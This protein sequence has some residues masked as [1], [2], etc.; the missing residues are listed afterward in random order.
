MW[1]YGNT[2][3]FTLR[4][5]FVVMPSLIA[6]AVCVVLLIGHVQSYQQRYNHHHNRIL[7]RSGS[8]V[9]S[10][11]ASLAPQPRAGV[12]RSSLDDEFV[13]SKPVVYVTDEQ[14]EG[15]LDDM[16]YSGDVKGYIKK[17]ALNVITED[18]AEYVEERI[19]ASGDADEIVALNEVLSIVNGR[20]QLTDGLVNSDEVFEKRLDRILFTPPNQRS[21]WLEDNRG[22]LT[23]GFV[24]YIQNE[25]KIATDSDS[26]VVLAS[27]LQL[28]GQATG[29]ELLEKDVS[30]ELF[31]SA[32]ATLGDQFKKEV[33]TIDSNFRDK[34]EQILAG[35]MFSNN[36]ILEDVLNNLHV[37]NE[38]FLSFLQNKVDLS[39]DMEERVGLQSLLDTISSGE[40]YENLYIYSH[41]FLLCILLL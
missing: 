13:S 24:E 31:Q 20:L 11:A 17:N 2:G 38:D 1:M 41:M 9:S 3:N 27:I 22:D 40:C 16:I 12:M 15:W 34:N 37:I 26:K 4:Q 33:K 5:L 25:M 23:G 35:L 18:F 6:A 8:I 7:P 19:N 32:D 30:K 36:D 29:K 14:L 21:K 10:R 28:I 39:R